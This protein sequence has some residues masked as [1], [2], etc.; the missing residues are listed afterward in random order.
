V[1]TQTLPQS[2]SY[3]AVL[4]NSPDRTAR[5]PVDA[6]VPAAA[7]RDQAIG[8]CW[9]SR[10]IQCFH[11]AASMEWRC[12][13]LSSAGPSPSVN[14][15]RTAR[16]WDT[17]D[18]A[19]PLRPSAGKWMHIGFVHSVIGTR[20]T[21]RSRGCRDRQVEEDLCCPSERNREADS[22][23][24]PLPHVGVGTCM[25]FA[26]ALHL[27]ICKSSQRRPRRSSSVRVQRPKS[28]RARTTSHCRQ[29]PKSSSTVVVLLTKSSEC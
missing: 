11:S 19:S 16:W 14:T 29:L 7:E 27:V 13:A 28:T 24:R 5:V 18:R 20:T 22:V 1:Q 6:S 2:I 17:S 26:N 9:W 15:T 23:R 25:P 4:W 12:S 8:I 3:L 10:Y 21:H